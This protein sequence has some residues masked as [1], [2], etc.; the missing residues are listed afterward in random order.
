MLRLAARP[1]A[2]SALGSAFRC[3]AAVAA[4]VVLAGC[5]GIGDD[6]SATE[7]T[8]STTVVASSGPVP[9]ESTQAA[10]VGAAEE[11]TDAAFAVACDGQP[12]EIA[13]PYDA[14]PGIVHPS[15]VVSGDET[16]WT[17]RPLILGAGW[18]QTWSPDAPLALL[19]VQLVVCLHRTASAPMRECTGYGTDAAGNPLVAVL[20]QVDYLVEV[21]EAATGSTVG[22]T[23]MTALDTDCPA[24]ITATEAGNVVPWYSLDTAALTA[25]VQP[26]IEP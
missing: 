15:V 24:T 5:L 16:G 7:T 19:D 6:G 8:V 10:D 23:T 1:A 14:A 21:R 22:S 18:T 9:D 20:Q 2:R 4:A 17:A 11:L 25:F 3:G 26:Y 12:V 13:S